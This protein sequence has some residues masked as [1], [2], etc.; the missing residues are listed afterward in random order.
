[1]PGNSFFQFSN[2]TLKIGPCGVKPFFAGLR[3]AIEPRIFFDEILKNLDLSR[4][5]DDLGFPR[6]FR[7]NP[8]KIFGELLPWRGKGTQIQIQE[9]IEI[10]S[11][12]SIIL[13]FRPSL[14]VTGCRHDQ[15][16]DGI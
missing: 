3:A 14:K 2:A 15:I 9:E 5:K 13:F 16:I 12:P 6:K 11:K 7:S 10:A 4:I 1:M 8:V